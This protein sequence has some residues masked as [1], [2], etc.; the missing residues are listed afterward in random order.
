MIGAGSLVT[1]NITEP[2]VYNGNP[3]R[4]TG[5]MS[6]YGHKLHFN[7]KGFASCPESG[8]KYRLNDARGE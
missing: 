5:W 1:T 6:A 3:T 8:E 2:G 7:D 4:Q